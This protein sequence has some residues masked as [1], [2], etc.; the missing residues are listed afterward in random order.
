MLFR[1]ALYFVRNFYSCGLI[2]RPHNVPVLDEGH[3]II[4]VL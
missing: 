3:A 1:E 2:W 4:H